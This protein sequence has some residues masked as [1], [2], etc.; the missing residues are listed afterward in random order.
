MLVTIGLC[1]FYW[2]NV[3][4]EQKSPKIRIRASSKEKVRLI[5]HG[6][7]EG[8]DQKHT[9]FINDSGRKP[10]GKAIGKIIFYCGSQLTFGT[11]KIIWVIFGHIP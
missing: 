8:N 7:W 5:C 1:T 10:K 11:K 6:E 3:D 2:T 4:W 9:K